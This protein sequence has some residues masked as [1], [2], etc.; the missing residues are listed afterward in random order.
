MRLPILLVLAGC[1]CAAQ[2]PHLSRKP[3]AASDTSSN[4]KLVT[5]TGTVSQIDDKSLVLEETDTRILTC[6]LVSSTK[7]PAQKINPGDRVRI[8]ARQDAEAFLTAEAVEVDSSAKSGTT[9]PAS[10]SV[11]TASNTPSA[12]APPTPDPVIYK[13]AKKDPDDEGPP[14]L[15]Y[16]K[17]KPRPYTEPA[18]E[19]AAAS[20]PSVP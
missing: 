6:K 1:T 11:V 2:R 3:A 20:A 15:R 19:T 4:E 18:E 9:L 12:P 7:L 17:P 8:S 5:L 13:P 16:G 14:H 10:A